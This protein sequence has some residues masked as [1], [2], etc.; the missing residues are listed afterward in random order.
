MLRLMILPAMAILLGATVLSAS[1]AS[2]GSPTAD[3]CQ[4]KPGPPA[5]PHLHWYYRVERA[6]HRHCWY[7]HSDD[8]RVRSS[9]GI[10]HV[11]P[12]NA[13]SQPVNP[14]GIG[15]LSPPRN[16]A[17]QAAQA[18]SADAT[19]PEAGSVAASSPGQAPIE[20]AARWP[21][22]PRAL[23]LDARVLTSRTASYTD[24]QPEEPAADNLEQMPSWSAT[25]VTSAQQDSAGAGQSLP[26]LRS[27]ALGLILF[28][29]F[30]GSIKF[31]RQL[32][33]AAGQ[34][35]DALRSQAARGFRSIWSGGLGA[36]VRVAKHVARESDL[37]LQ[38]LMDVLRR[39]DADAGSPRSFTPAGSQPKAYPTNRRSDPQLRRQSYFSTRDLEPQPRS[40]ERK[41]TKIRTAVVERPMQLIRSH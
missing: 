23:D 24:E 4:S 35:H 20:F 27:G 14:A 22:L 33:G 36:S 30:W 7:L 25:A 1:Q 12:P 2:Y 28:I 38:E 6:S 19:G 9:A 3:A 8:L 17:V 18:N 29:L 39:I 21:S 31:A 34:P 15:K 13:A 40:L 37:G 32:N 41:L 11:A 10:T 5:P 16:S 26:M